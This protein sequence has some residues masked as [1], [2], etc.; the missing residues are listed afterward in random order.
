[1]SQAARTREERRGEQWRRALGGSL[2]PGDE[3]ARGAQ[4]EQ[5]PLGHEAA[6]GDNSPQTGKA[7]KRHDRR[8]LGG[9]QGD[10]GT[11]Y[12]QPTDL[13]AQ[14]SRRGKATG[15]NNTHTKGGSRRGAPRGRQRPGSPGVRLSKNRARP[16]DAVAELHGDDSGVCEAQ[17]L[18]G[19]ASIA[20]R[21]Q[22]EPGSAPPVG[23]S[24]RASGV[25][26]AACGWPG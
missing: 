26:R 6:N 22:Q 4:A 17:R 11:K 3:S 7:D 14:T 2:G 10:Q 19:G 13:N 8:G 9:R 16:E 1:M 25:Q 21:G 5:E 15:R 12:L 20:G 24:P 23:Q 18:A